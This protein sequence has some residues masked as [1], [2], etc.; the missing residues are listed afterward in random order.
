MAQIDSLQSALHLSSIGTAGAAAANSG[1][2]S[3]KTGKPVTK[4]SRFASMVE[5]K[6]AENQMI[7]AGLPPEI[8]GMEFE[9]ALV[10][11]KDKA[12]LASD[13]AKSDFNLE[14][15]K[16]YRKAIGDLIRFIVHTNYEVKMNIRR[17]PS[18]RFKTEKFYLINIVDEKIDKLAS[19]ILANHLETMQILVRI[20]EING[21]LVDLIT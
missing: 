7:S 3:A 2:K 15:F 10:Y 9:D 13:V 14:S 12:D 21:I 6:V 5:Q 8:A 4:K 11:L 17:R 18:K 1:N 19:D 20:D 16:S